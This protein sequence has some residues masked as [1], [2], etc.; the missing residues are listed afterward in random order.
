MLRLIKR[1]VLVLSL[2]LLC[3]IVCAWAETELATDVTAKC[4]LTATV[5][6][7]LTK[8]VCNEK[9]DSCWDGLEDG[10]LTVKLPAGKT[11][12]GIMLS[13]FCD[14]PHLAVYDADGTLLA[15]WDDGYYNTWIPF[16]QPSSE[17]TIQRAEE[18]QLVISRMHVMTPGKLPDWVQQWTRLEGDADLLLI[19]THPDDD[20]L[21]FGGLLPT[22]AGERQMKVLVSY[23]VGGLH[24]TRRIELLNALWHCGV[25]YYPEIGS[26][27]DQSARTIKGTYEAWGGE[28]NIDLHITRLLRKWNPRVV[29]TQDLEGEYGHNHHRVTTKAVAKAVTSLCGDESYDPQSVAQW[30]IADPQKLYIH[31]YD[32]NQVVYDWEQPLSAFG[33]KNGLTIA[34]E[35]FKLHVSQQTGK[36]QVSIKSAYNCALFGLYYTTVGPDVEG[37]DMFENVQW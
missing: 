22:Y 20:I 19:A 28:E 31:L 34:R 36:Y 10:T 21:W 27:P 2:L 24:R 23:M 13:F 6:Q 30:G 14:V 16:S 37:V 1:L 5:N 15:D 29:V 33:G 7:K 26:F 17:F 4:Q 32:E 8:R 3:G 35:A 12:Q 9:I 11:A 25:R 18:G